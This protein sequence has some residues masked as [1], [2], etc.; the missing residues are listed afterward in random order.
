LLRGVEIE[1]KLACHF[2]DWERI[3]VFIW[4]KGGEVVKVVI[5]K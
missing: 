2:V 5:K 3:W 4:T 1:G